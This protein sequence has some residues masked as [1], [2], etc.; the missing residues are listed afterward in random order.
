M[1]NKT[2]G[3]WENNAALLKMKQQEAE[4]LYGRQH[5]PY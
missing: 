1:K 3:F 4:V 2:S 5:H